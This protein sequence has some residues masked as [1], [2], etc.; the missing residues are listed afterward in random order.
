MQAFNQNNVTL[1]DLAEKSIESLSLYDI[2]AAGREYDVD[3]MIWGTGFD[4][5][6][7][8]SPDRRAGIA[9]RGRNGKLLEQ[10][11]EE[12]VAT[13]H[14]ASTRDFPNLFFPYRQT[15]STVNNVHIFETQSD[16]AMHTIKE[17]ERRHPEREVLIEPTYEA[18]E[19][20]AMRIVANAASL[21]GLAGSIPSLFNREG[22][23]DEDVKTT[24]RE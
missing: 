24:T 16:H 20:W 13:L 21:A 8:Q 1:I 18:V 11:W 14:G 9:I 17:A 19:G 15:G 5:S 22:R 3:V 6:L 23:V 10:K 12:G 4:F 7:G 2:R